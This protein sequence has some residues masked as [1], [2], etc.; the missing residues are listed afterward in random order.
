MQGGTDVELRLA[1]AEALARLP[2]DGLALGGFSV[3]EPTRR[4]TARSPQVA[5]RYADASGRAT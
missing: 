3:G 4:C 1:H 5:P 2:F